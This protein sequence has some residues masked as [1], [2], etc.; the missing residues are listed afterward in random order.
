VIKSE[1]HVEK[2][3]VVKIKGE[4]KIFYP[5]FYISLSFFK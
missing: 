5:S 4:K 2:N 3:K 1:I